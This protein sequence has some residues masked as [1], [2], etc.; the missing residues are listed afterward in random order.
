MKGLIESRNRVLAFPNTP[1]FQYSKNPD[2]LD[3]TK[4]FKYALAHVTGDPEWHLI[5]GVLD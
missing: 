1:I 2:H 5:R 4:L 3:R